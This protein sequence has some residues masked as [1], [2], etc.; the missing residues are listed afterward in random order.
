MNATVRAMTACLVSAGIVLISAVP[1]NAQGITR[2]PAG[3]AILLRT[4]SAINPASV[5]VGDV[6]NLSVA[7]D[8]TVGGRVVFKAGANARAE[9]VKAERRG[10]AGKPDL[11]AITV[12]SVQ[13][14]DGASVPVS[15]TKTVEGEDKMVVTIIL[16][17]VC[18]PFIFMKG[19][20]AQIASGTEINTSTNGVVEIKAVPVLGS[21]SGS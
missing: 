12:Q 6:L 21:S 4:T 16:T 18:L 19:G 13:A 14:V 17:L 11:I 15:T 2:V 1:A 10:I 7:N 5:R 3:T 20:E 9:V 8:V